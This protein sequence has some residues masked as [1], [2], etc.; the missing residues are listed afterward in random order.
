MFI[1]NV[2]AGT[3]GV[4]CYIIGDNETKKGAVIDPGGNAH[5]IIRV[6]N[7]NKINV[8]YI[9][10]THGH[11]DHIG[12]VEELKEKTNA[13]IL[14]HEEE[15][16]ILNDAQNNLTVAIGMGEIKIEADEY[17]KENQVVK[18]GNLELKIIH[19]PG[20]TPGCMCI[21]VDDV[22]FTGDTLFAGSIGRTDLPGGDYD[23][24][25][26]SVKKLSKFDEEITIYPGH[27]PS[28][29]IGIEQRMNPYMKS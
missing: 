22:M 25:L 28:S 4:N 26:N 20:H 19:T 12:A 24:I 18:I 5:E 2:L 23:T 10:L 29:K 1:H 8:E 14:A 27:G 9:I 11:G 13:K 3:Y 21:M 17:L 15:K 16:Y 7:D 6:I